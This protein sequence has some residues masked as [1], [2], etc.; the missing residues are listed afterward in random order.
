MCAQEACDRAI[1]VMLARKPDTREKVSVVFAVSKAGDWGA[2]ASADGFTAWNCLD[3]VVESRR[4][5]G[6]A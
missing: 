5:P 6:R 1:D 2:A 3:G 4:I